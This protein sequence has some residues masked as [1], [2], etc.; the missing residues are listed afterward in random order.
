MV[1]TEEHSLPTI[2]ELTVPEINLST[3]SLRAASFHLGKACEKEN[4]VRLCFI[5]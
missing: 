3:S 1:L 5:I 2:E 4:N